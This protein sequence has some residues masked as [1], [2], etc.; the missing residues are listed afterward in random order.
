MWSFTLVCSY[1]VP[2]WTLGAL[3]DRLLRVRRA[4]HVF[5]ASGCKK[6]CMVI[7]QILFCTKLPWPHGPQNKANYFLEVFR[8]S[9]SEKKTFRVGGPQSP[10]SICSSSIL[11]FIFTHFFLE[12]KIKANEVVLYWFH[13]QTRTFFVITSCSCTLRSAAQMARQ[14][15]SDWRIEDKSK[16]APTSFF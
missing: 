4:V 13:L 12:T 3:F 7:Q 14:V 8:T 15:F 9:K 10:F 16:T 5:G 11:F 2:C 1:P 6:P